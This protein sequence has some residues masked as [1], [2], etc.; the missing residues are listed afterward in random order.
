M[1]PSAPL[2]G[3]HRN[4]THA[5][6]FHGNDAEGPD[7]NHYSSLDVLIIRQLTQSNRQG[8]YFASPGVVLTLK[9][10]LE[11]RGNDPGTVAL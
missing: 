4:V 9:R 11:I 3:C 1:R 10:R 8:V 2:F 5:H 6:K 7:L